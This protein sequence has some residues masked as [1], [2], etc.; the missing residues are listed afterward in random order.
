V[1]IE[2]IVIVC[3]IKYVVNTY[4]ANKKVYVQVMES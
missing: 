3:F 2:W 1:S 4:I